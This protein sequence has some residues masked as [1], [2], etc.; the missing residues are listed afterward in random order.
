MEV[1]VFSD[2]GTNKVILENVETIIHTMQIP[3]SLFF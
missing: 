1:N 2:F 3:L